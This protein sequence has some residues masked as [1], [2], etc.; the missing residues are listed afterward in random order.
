M[1]KEI[2]L[3]LNRLI[4]HCYENQ[5]KELLDSYKRFSIILSR[6]ETKINE[7]YKEREITIYNLFRSECEIVN[8]IIIGLSHHI[9]FCHRGYTN[10]K[11]EFIDVYKNILYF[12]LNYGYLNY[13][14]L[15][16]SND[17]NNI[18]RIRDVL[19]SF[20]LDNKPSDKSK[21]EV[22]NSYN[23][24][25]ILRTNGYKYSYLGRCWYFI[26][27]NNN[28]SKHMKWIK[29]SDKNAKTVIVNENKIT[30]NIHAKIVVSGNSYFVKDIL[31][32]NGYKFSDKAWKKYINAS[33]Y[34][35]EKQDI[36][37]KLPVGQG[38]KVSIEY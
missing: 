11:K 30:I 9:D 29:G 14:E 31:K 22:Y 3:I 8:S 4:E 35:T 38:L 6:R 12:C 7:S 32:D 37:K 24:K 16:G 21:I 25:N 20:W 34:L 2:K 23:L 17:F 26:L 36:L 28:I 33:D 15:T 27:P 10:N 1:D 5:S 13:D 19:E 18:K